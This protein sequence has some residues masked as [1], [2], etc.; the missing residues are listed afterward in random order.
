M[1][2]YMKPR[3]HFGWIAG[4][5]L[6]FILTYLSQSDLIEPQ[7]QE[8]YGNLYV[9]VIMPDGTKLPGVLCTLYGTSVTTRTTISNERGEIRML[10]LPPG[11]YDIRFE[12]E[13]F[14]TVE[15]KDVVINVGKNTSLE[16]FMEPVTG[17]FDIQE[18]SSA[19]HWD[20]Y[21]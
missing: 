3:I 6:L 16:V 15:R 17:T 10:D 13:G 21:R 5:P 14:V 20:C 11:P 9:T 19:S 8:S 12:I 7:A 4:L 1:N 2:I 18:P